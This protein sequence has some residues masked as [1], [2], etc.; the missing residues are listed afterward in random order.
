KPYSITDANG[1][2]PVTGTFN[3][4]QPTAVS[5]SILI[6]TNVQC[7]GATSGAVTIQG[8]GG[9]G[10]LTY[11]LSGALLAIPLSNNTGVFTGLAAGSHTATVTD[12]NNCQS[13]VAVV[14]TTIQ[15]NSVL[16]VTPHTK[17]YSDVVEFK[18]TI[19][20]VGPPASCAPAEKASFKV[21]DQ[22]MG[23][24]NFV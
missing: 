6:Q 7:S 14:I 23:E 15:T 13:T 12:A 17:Q 1:C 19:A 16:I 21:G 3:V 9:T 4:I 11:S 2:G 22:V 18:V 24:A 8:G 20:P 5:S 10:S